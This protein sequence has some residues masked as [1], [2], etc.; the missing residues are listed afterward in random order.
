MHLTRHTDYALRVMLYLAV[1]PDRRVTIAAIAAG[2]NIPRQHLMKTVNEL[3]RLGYVDALRGRGGGLS[4]G[5][6]PTKVSL[7]ALI[8]DLEPEKPLIDCQRPQCPT[9]GVCRLVGALKAAETAFYAALGE[10][11]LADMVENRSQLAA[12]LGIDA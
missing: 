8:R 2:F 3:S 11:T 4:L 6:D 9:V 10:Y 12:R 7:D 1:E 5:C